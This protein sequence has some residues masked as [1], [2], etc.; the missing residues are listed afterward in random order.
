[1]PKFKLNKLI[2]DG[3]KETYANNGQ[4]AIYKKITSSEHKNYLV[5]KIIEEASEIPLNATNQEI[6]DE[7]ADVRQALED[8][9]VLCN[10]DESQVETAKQKIFDK[11]R[12]FSEATFIT[13]LELSDNDP[14]V[15]Y[16][17]KNPD[18]FPEK[19]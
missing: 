12:G 9:M 17:R 11:K 7:I 1:M 18:L 4:T 5:S 15:E 14:W 16:Y 2:R 3:L 8:L 6:I 13:T 19:K 10:I